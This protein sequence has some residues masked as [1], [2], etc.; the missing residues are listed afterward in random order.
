MEN[1]IEFFKKHKIKVLSILLVIFF[2][3]SCG[4][5]RDISKLEK[6]QVKNLAT[7][8]SLNLIVNKQ[9][10]QI[11]IEKIKI[12]TF[13]DNWITE[14]NRG[15]QLMELHFVVKNNLKELQPQ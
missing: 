8:D 14:K 6:T 2:F 5:S 1:I 11:K 3:K 10:E 12:H 4:G 9:K 7:I 15:G 13:Y